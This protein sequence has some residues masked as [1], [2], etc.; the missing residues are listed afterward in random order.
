MLRLPSLLIKRSGSALTVFVLAVFFLMPGREANGSQDQPYRFQPGLSVIKERG[1]S[2]R[3]L[4]LLID[5]LKNGTGFT[6]L[7]VNESGRVVLGNR[8]NVSRGSSSAREL[9]VAAIDSRDSFILENSNYSQAIAFGEIESCITY[10]DEN[11]Q[12]HAV[13]RLRLDLS[14]FAG[15]RGPGE[16]IASFDPAL[17]VL[18]EL[19]HGVLQLRDSLSAADQLGE[20]ERHINRIR[21]ELGLP[22]RE[23]YRPRGWR[24][25]SPGHSAES[26]QAE[27]RFSQLNP[28]KN[29]KKSFYLVFDVDRVCDVL[30]MQSLPPGRAEIFVATR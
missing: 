11:N 2:R 22:E 10:V 1:F 9:L 12:K 16:A 4:Q 24:A 6:D 26:L 15:L 5:G 19:A 17:V 25:V 18:H 21:S 30:L 7:F 14:D 29:G 13:W 27:F 20:C 28:S 3:N 8:E 23:T